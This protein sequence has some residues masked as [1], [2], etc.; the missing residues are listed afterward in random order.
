MPI[1][2]II[3]YIYDTKMCVQKLERIENICNKGVSIMK[4]HGPN[5]VSFL[6]NQTVQPTNFF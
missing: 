3:Y 4:L 5:E 2:L 6:Q 1:I